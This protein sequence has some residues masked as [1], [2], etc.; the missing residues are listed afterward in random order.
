[1]PRA[2]RAPIV[3]NSEAVIVHF[4]V[5]LASWGLPKRREAVPLSAARNSFPAAWANSSGSLLPVTSGQKIAAGD[6]APHRLGA[7]SISIVHPRLCDDERVSSGSCVDGPRLARD[8][9]ACVDRR[10][11]AVMC[12]ACWRGRGRRP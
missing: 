10:S 7:P 12:P 1:S 11:L 2:H 4:L 5:P 3:E 9:F 6:S 8:L